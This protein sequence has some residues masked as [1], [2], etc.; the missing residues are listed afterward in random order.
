MS[1]GTPCRIRSQCPFSGVDVQTI[2]H[3]TKFLARPEEGNPLRRHFDWGSGS[4]IARDAPSSLPRVEASESTDL[5]LVPSAQSTDD[6]V[7]YGGHDSVGFLQGRPNGLV[8]LFGQIGSG[9]LAHPRRITKKS[10][11]VLPGV[12]DAGS[13]RMVGQA[14][15]NR[16]S[17][18]RLP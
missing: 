6:A 9:H 17:G 14:G 2:N 15:R 1:P 11:T 13:C 16:R 4:W 8:N 10:I 3:F 5:N 12:P 18:R 7:K